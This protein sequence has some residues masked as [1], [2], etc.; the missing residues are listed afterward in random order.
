VVLFLQT[1]TYMLN[2]FV[3]SEVLSAATKTYIFNNKL[4]SNPLQI[5]G[6][7]SFTIATSRLE[8]IQRFLDGSVLV[9]EANVTE[10]LTSLR[11]SDDKEVTFYSQPIKIEFPKSL[12]DTF[13]PGMDFDAVVN[14]FERVFFHT[15]SCLLR[16]E[17]FHGLRLSKLG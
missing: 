5:N 8:E 9:F 13:K 6:N 7:A 11:Q 2:I 10:S 1:L 15:L 3:H 14:I 4:A 12:P 16:F 17:Q